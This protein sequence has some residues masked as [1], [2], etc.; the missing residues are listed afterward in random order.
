[1]VWREQRRPAKNERGS[2][3]VERTARIGWSL[4]PWSGPFVIAMQLGPVAVMARRPVLL[5]VD[6]PPGRW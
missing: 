6:G 5:I 2:R 3:V 1:M 4:T